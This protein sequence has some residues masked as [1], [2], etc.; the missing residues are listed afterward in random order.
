MQFLWS[1]GKLRGSMLQEVSWEGYCMVERKE[2]KDQVIMKGWSVV[3]IIVNSMN[4]G[5][6]VTTLQTKGDDTIVIMHQE[7][8][9]ICDMAQVLTWYRATCVQ[10]CTTPK[11]IA[12]DTLVKL[13]S[14]LSLLVF[15]RIMKNAKRRDCMQ[16]WKTAV[17]LGGIVSTSLACPSCCICKQAR[18][19]VIDL[20]WIW[21]KWSH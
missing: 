1:E 16:C 3:D 17:S 21:Q 12:L 13:R 18:K 2:C 15:R 7:N 11:C 14:L 9:W 5:V 20:H 6:D 8:V 10:V 4:Q 19:S